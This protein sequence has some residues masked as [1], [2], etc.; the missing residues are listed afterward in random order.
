QYN[1]NAPFFY[2]NPAFGIDNQSVANTPIAIFRC[3]MAPVRNAYTYTFNFPGYPAITWQAWPADYS[4]LAGVSS[5]LTQYLGLAYSGD[6]LLGVLQP[7]QGTKIAQILDGTSNTILIAEIAGKNELYQGGKDSGQQLSGFFGGE[8]GWA[9]A[10]SG[11]SQ[12]YGSSAD[13]TIT[14]G[15]CG[16]NCSNDYGL[17]GFHTGGAN[18]LFADASAHFIPQATD[19]RVLIALITRSGGEAL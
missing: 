1:V 3:P 12:L 14:P 10:T 18:M 5:S 9:D 16:I 4:P 8:G 19:I 15:T 13:G 7:D 11:A 17:Y 6:S 2:T